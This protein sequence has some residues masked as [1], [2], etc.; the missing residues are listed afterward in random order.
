[1]TTQNATALDHVPI[2]YSFRRCPY[3]IRARLAL[4][5]TQ[6]PVLLREVKLAEKPQALLHVSPKGT[7]PVLVTRAGCVLEESLDIMGWALS[8]LDP[9]HPW[10]A[11]TSLEDPLL[12]RNDDEFKHWLDRYKYAD[13]YPEHSAEYYRSHA[14]VFLGSL[15]RRLAYAPWL[16]GEYGGALDAAIMPFVRQFAT[17]DRQ[18]FEQT[19]YP[20]LQRWLQRWL[21][22]PLFIGVMDKWDPWKTDDQPLL[23]PPDP[24]ALADE[25]R[26]FSAL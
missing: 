12:E 18:W 22:S 15:E 24:V 23:W 25:A 14:E 7:V 17:V 20:A 10:R 11:G 26:R 9:T 16:S 8:L 13:R 5:T 2:L 6:H 4:A 21:R 3:A 1:M 19:P